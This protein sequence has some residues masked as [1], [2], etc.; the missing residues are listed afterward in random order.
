M[1]VQWNRQELLDVP[2]MVQEATS[3]SNGTSSHYE[4]SAPQK[5]GERFS[6]RR[7]EPQKERKALYPMPLRRGCNSEHTCDA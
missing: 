5:K 2:L 6:E 1:F 3:Q 4:A 7:D